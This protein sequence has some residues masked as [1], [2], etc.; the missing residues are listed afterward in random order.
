MERGC[1]RRKSDGVGTKRAGARSRLYILICCRQYI[2]KLEFI[3]C[4]RQR[5]VDWIDRHYGCH[6]EAGVAR[7]ERGT[8]DVWER[9][10]RVWFTLVWLYEPRQGRIN[11]TKERV[12]RREESRIGRADAETR[13]H[14]AKER[15]RRIERRET[16]LHVPSW[17][18]ILFEN[19]RRM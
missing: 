9:T 11:T 4:Q 12:R 15:E 19:T 7:S 13:E 18:D 17:R 10:F 5:S 6:T 14:R 1:R 3:R 16:A 8:R 2:F